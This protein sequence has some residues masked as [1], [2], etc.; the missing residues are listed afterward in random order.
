MIWEKSYRIFSQPDAEEME[1]A[2][3]PRGGDVADSSAIE[4]AKQD[5]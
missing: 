2:T 4:S 5:R 3:S 1:G